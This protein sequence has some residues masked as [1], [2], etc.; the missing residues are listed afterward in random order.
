MPAGA[1]RFVE[2]ADTPGPGLKPMKKTLRTL[3]LLGSGLV[4]LSFGVFVVNQTVQVVEMAGQAHPTL[5][6]VTLWVLVVTYS[7]L[8][9]VPIVIVMRMPRALTPPA[10]DSGP[11]FEAHLGALGRRL[12]SNPRVPTPLGSSPARRDVEDA[13]RTLDVEANAVVKQMA[14]TVFLT[15]AVSQSGRLDA[16][17]VLMAQSRMIW[18]VAHLYYQRPSLREMAH[19]YTNVAATA[20]VAGELDDIELHQMI[21]PV[22]AAS[23]GTVG[24]AI[25]GFQVFTTIAVNSLLSGSAN[26]FLTLRVGMIAKAYCGSLVA[27]PRTKLRRSATAEAARLLSGIVKESGARVRDALWQEVKQKLPRPWPM[28]KA[29]AETV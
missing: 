3:L 21:Q 11:E 1:G 8:I 19:L 15:T 24:G 22:V 10:A 16:L 23:L 13:L 14:T 4:L 17:L 2:S 9:G 6:T 27:Q 7:G 20:F 18:R 28:R 26:A 12:E 25:P 29:Q 5:G